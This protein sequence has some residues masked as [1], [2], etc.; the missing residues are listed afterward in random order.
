MK[1]VLALILCLAL[2]LSVTLP[3]TLAVSAAEDSVTGDFAAEETSQPT[4]TSTETGAPDESG[5]T[6]T[7]TGETTG[8]TQPDTTDETGDTTGD[9][10]DGNG[11]S[12]GSTDATE[13]PAETDPTETTAPQCTCGREDG[14]HDEDCPCYEVELT[15]YERLMATTS[16]EEFDAIIAECTEE[17]LIFSCEEF[18]NLDDHYIYLTTGEYPSHEP[19][20]DYVSETVNFTN[21]APLVNSGK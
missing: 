15:L 8:E 3:G 18:D 17:Q 13:A 20:V 1:K 10:A 21:V 7:T 9:T 5:S 4:E 19:I 16:V 2:V 12:N 6:E 11:D 14:E